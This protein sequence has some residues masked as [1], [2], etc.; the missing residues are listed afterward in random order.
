LIAGRQRMPPLP[1]PLKYSQ[2]PDGMILES[3]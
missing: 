2:L 3:L 1:P